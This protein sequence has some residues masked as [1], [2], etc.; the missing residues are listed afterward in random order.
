MISD[1]VSAI[2]FLEATS[3]AYNKGYSGLEEAYGADL[4]DW[5]DYF[6]E[7]K[8]KHNDEFQF[9]SAAYWKSRMRGAQHAV[10]FTRNQKESS[11]NTKT[12]KRIYFDLTQELSKTLREY[13]RSQRTTL[14]ST[15]V[16]AFSVLLHRYFRQDDILIGYPVNIRPP[17]Y[18]NLFGFFVN[19]IALR[20]D[21]SGDPTFEQLVKRVS[22]A[23]KADKKYQS[24][25]ALDIVRE[26][27]KT[28]SGFNGRVFNVSMAQTVSRLV[29]LRLDGI[30]SEPLEAEYNDVNDDLSLSYELLE[31][32]RIGLWIE[33]RESLF[34]SDLI[35]QMIEHMKSLLQQTV[36]EPAQKISAYSLLT[37]DESS[38]LLQEWSA[39]DSAS[40]HAS[41][42]KTIHGLI[43]EYAR[44]NPCSTA[45]VYQSREISYAQMNSQANRLARHIR[46]QG[47]SSGESVA[48]CLERGPYMIFALIAV[49]KAGCT[50]VPI[51]PC[52]PK[53]RLK[54]IL[55]DANARVV[56]TEEALLGEFEA[57]GLRTIICAD[58]YQEKSESLADHN[59]DIALG[60]DD[61][62]YII[63]TSGS[64]GDPKGVLLSHGNVTPRLLWLRDEMDIDASD[65]VLQNTD[66]SF[67]VSV[68]E[69]FCPLM[70]GA[71]LILTETA[72]YKDPSYLIDLIKHNKVTTAFFVPSLLNSILAVLKDQHLCNFKRV[73]AA[74]EA[75]SPTLVNTFYKK[76]S[77]NLYNIYGPTEGAI[78]AAYKLCVASNVMDTV[79]IGRPISDTRLYVLD[80]HQRPQPIGVAGEL[81]IGGAGVA[82]G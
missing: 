59:L 53:Q 81:Y 32:G 41:A 44:T 74:G 14:F 17:G 18:K 79:P 67:D 61:S 70:A 54:F 56:I 29:N 5:N 58:T 46:R 48:L 31:N 34:S 65:V 10:D 35:D 60:G 57:Q 63:Y 75:L 62:A 72:Y 26:I 66:Y 43:E 64:T 82:Q 38:T 47:V 24:F 8:V 39:P 37:E 27:R 51:P 11:S 9:E 1:G 6:S 71:K 15:L 21:L 77:G 13:S 40:T 73:L 36:D 68:V 12:G 2:L 50:Y 52:F 49:L 23:R 78:Y 16:S 4:K 76:C 28:V 69:I 45:L 55:A 19:I 3:I 42:K 25:P 80:Q 20:V 22:V 33:Y 30:S 7:E